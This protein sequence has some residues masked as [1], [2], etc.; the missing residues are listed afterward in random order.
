MVERPM[1]LG[2]SVHLL[3]SLTV[4]LD[5]LVAHP[6]TFSSRAQRLSLT[7]VTLYVSWILVCSHFNRVF[8]YPFLNKL[9]W[10]K[11]RVYA[12]CMCC[13]Q[14][15]WPCY[16]WRTLT[17]CLPVIGRHMQMLHSPGCPVYAENASRSIKYGLIALHALQM[18]V[19][20]PASSIFPVLWS[21]ICLVRC[22][23]DTLATWVELH[24]APGT[25]GWYCNSS[26]S[27]FSTAC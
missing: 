7:L 14:T 22:L 18:S 26:N 24:T 3:N 10:P 9:P 16:P 15:D 12:T 11:V 13:V 21:R 1:W 6:R 27:A 19:M 8:P 25:W 4:W 2:M 17:A 23:M 5:L 20:L